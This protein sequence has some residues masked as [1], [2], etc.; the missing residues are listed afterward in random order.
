VLVIEWLKKEME[1]EIDRLRERLAKALAY[2]RDWELAEEEV[3]RLQAVNAQLRKQLEEMRHS[4]ID[5]GD[6]EKLDFS[7]NAEGYGCK[8]EE[9]GENIIIDY[10]RRGSANK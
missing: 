5:R 10:G 4:A 8:E 9:E 7:A 2:R 3:E 6:T 1:K